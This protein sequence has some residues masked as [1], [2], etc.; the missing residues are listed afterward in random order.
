[1]RPQPLT[2]PKKKLNTNR[3]IEDLE[4]RVDNLK[5]LYA[6]EQNR[7]AALTLSMQTQKAEHDLAMQKLKEVVSSKNDKLVQMVK[8]GKKNMN[9]IIQELIRKS[10][11]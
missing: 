10:A 1:V 11:T 7:N 4:A 8:D 3:Y 9:A 6:E 5:S 2:G